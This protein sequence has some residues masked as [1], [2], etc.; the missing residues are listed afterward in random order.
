MG[1]KLTSSLRRQRALGVLRSLLADGAV[2]NFQYP[3]GRFLPYSQ[4]GK[5]RAS[6]GTLLIA[7]Q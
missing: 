7:P 6:A 3:L 4:F 1:K 5:A 2:V